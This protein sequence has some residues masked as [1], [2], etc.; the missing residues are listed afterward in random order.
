MERAAR[1]ST[2]QIT[3]QELRDFNRIDIY[4]KAEDFSKYDF[5]YYT[6]LDT[7]SKILESR[8]FWVS[9]MTN[10]NDKSETELHPKLADHIHALCFC[11]SKTEKIPMWY[12]YAGLAGRGVSIGFTPMTMLRLLQSVEEVEVVGEEGVKLRKDADFA[13]QYGWVYYRDSSNRINYKRQWYEIENESFFKRD[14]F[15]IK[16]VKYVFILP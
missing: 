7:A 14:N 2:K 1:M 9:N 8:S 6:D 4:G 15:F 5:W 13:L 3:A 12:L 11:N 16:D 10:M